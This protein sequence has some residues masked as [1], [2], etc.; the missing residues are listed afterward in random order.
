M[1]YVGIFKYNFIVKEEND[2]DESDSDS[3]LAYPSCGECGKMFPMKVALAQHMIMQ[4]KEENEGNNDNG[5][6]EN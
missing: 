5:E 3:V 1:C 2:D 4:H 6:E